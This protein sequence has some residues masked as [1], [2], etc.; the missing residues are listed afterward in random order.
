MNIIEF[1]FEVF[2]EDMSMYSNFE[3]VNYNNAE[4]VLASWSQQI[5]L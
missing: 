2:H 1:T 3:R 5:V 4:D